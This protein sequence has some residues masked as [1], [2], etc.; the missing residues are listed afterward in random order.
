MTAVLSFL[1]AGDYTIAREVI[2]RGFA[3]LFFI[4]FLSAW[5]QFPALLGEHGLT[6]APR[7]I[8][9]HH[10]RAGTDACSGGNASP[11]PIVDCTSCAASA[12]SLAVSVIAGLPQA[13]PA[14]T[15]IPVFWLMWWLYFSIVAI[16][17]RFYGFGWESLLLEAGFLV[18]FLGS[19]EVAPPLL[20]ILFPAVLRRP[21]RVRGGHDQDARGQLLAG[22][23]RH[24]LSPSDP[25]HAQSVQ[26]PCAPDARLVAPRGDSGQPYR[27]AQR[28]VAALPAPTHRVLRRRWSS[29]SR[30]S[31]SSSPAITPG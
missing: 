11:T 3:L 12:C 25:A 8:A 22:P 23:V 13:G 5:N 29:S 14:W 16:G 17:Q 24:G 21:H 31:H 19:H 2:Q 26:P 15:M 28:T 10:R 30:S 20:M 4:A 18:G 27:P 1:S 6:P 9:A 7:F